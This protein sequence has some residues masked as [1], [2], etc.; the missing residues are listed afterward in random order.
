MIQVAISGIAGRMGRSLLA[1]I[2]EQSQEWKLVGAL[3]A[4]QSPWL[5]KDAGEADGKG[6]L[7]VKVSHEIETL[8]SGCQVLIE[9]SASQA[10]LS[11]LR[12]AVGRGLPMVIGTTGFSQEEYAEAASLAPGIPCVMSSNMSLGMN[13]MFALV[14]QASK[15]L[16]DYDAEIIET[17]HAK[18]I[19]APSGSAKTLLRIIEQA[20]GGVVDVTHGRQGDVGER[21]K[22]TVG[23]HA[24]RG[25][26]IVGDHTVL[27][28]G[29]F[30]RLELT[31]R[32]HGREV[33]AR[34][35]L[36]AAQFIAKAPKGLYSMKEVL[37]L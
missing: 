22:G 14:E 11:H 36:A 13:V 2:R 27:L 9:F 29:P 16:R 7:G 30:E 20:R 23:M 18:K 35:A 4:I 8:A 26:D 10:T 19:D 37:G 3:E 25:G 34:G 21:S 15:T 31:H 5:G 32:A 1:L 17:H 6:P 28:A 24:V 12:F 33:F